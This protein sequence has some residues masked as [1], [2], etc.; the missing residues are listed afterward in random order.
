MPT[1]TP[2]VAERI[3]DRSQRSQLA[4]LL[5][6]I[7]R[8]SDR[9]VDAALAQLP[10]PHPDA[11]VVG[12]T[13]PPGA[14][15]STVSSALATKFR[16]RGETVGVLAVDPSSPFSGGAVLGDRV[17][18][19]E[20]L[21]DDGVFIRSMASRGELGGLS[22]A[23]PQA[24][25][26]MLAFGFDWV[27][28][29]TVGIG[30]SEIGVAEH[31]D[32]TLLVLTP[33]MGDSVQAI[34]AGVMEIADILVMNKADRDGAKESAR[35]LAFTVG[36]SP[37]G[38]DS[39][40]VPVVATVATAPSGIDEL[41]DAL[42]AHRRSMV[43]SGV[44]EVKRGARRVAQWKLT[45]QRLWLERLDQLMATSR[46]KELDDAVASGVLSSYRGATALIENAEE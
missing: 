40:I 41:I 39:W 22:S 42:D 7:E 20:H 8:D 26:A 13:G 3:L 17:R 34:K 35:E 25:T 32:T 37:L 1:Q 5:T 18:M 27:L 6:R 38:P 31:V 44:I 28:V 36:H 30:Q 16:S 4:R 29:E 14:G 15:K 45:C 19:M 46:G 2:T 33:G 10:E 43:E 9:G 12:V 21:A 24:V 11:W 23:I